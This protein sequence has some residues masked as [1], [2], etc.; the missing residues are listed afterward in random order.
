MTDNMMLDHAREILK[1]TADDAPVHIDIVEPG[2]V[3]VQGGDSAEHVYLLMR[4]RLQGEVPLHVGAQLMA[5][6]PHVVEYEPGTLI[7]ATQILT[8]S[9]HPST[10]TVTRRSTLAVLSREDFETLARTEVAFMGAV[11]RLALQQQRAS[12]TPAIAHHDPHV[13]VVLPLSAGLHPFSEQLVAHLRP[14][15]TATLINLAT[16]D[17]S[18]VTERMN[19]HDY[20]VVQG[21]S[22]SANE[23]R[24]TRLLQDSADQVLLVGRDEDLRRAD[25]PLLAL[26]E[27]FATEVKTELVIVHPRRDTQPKNTAALVKHYPVSQ[28]HHLAIDESRDYARL[29]RHLRG[30]AV[31]IVFGGGGM[32]GMAHVGVYKAML[33][34]GIVADYV[35]GT[36][37]GSIVAAQVGQEDSPEK[38]FQE[39]RDN[40]LT[41]KAVMQLTLPY[42]SF[43]TAEAINAA[44][45]KLFG[46][47]DIEDLWIPVFTIATNLTQARMEVL[48]TGSLHHAVRASSSLAGIHPPVIAENNDVLIDGGGFNNTPADVMRQ[49]VTSGTVIAVDLG[50]TKR[51]FPEFNMGYSLNG[52]SVLL[53]RLNPFRRE[54]ITFP[55]ITTTM[56][57]SNALWSMQA[58]ELQIAA[59]DLVL[60]PPVNDYGLFDLGAA[61]ELFNGGYES[62]GEPIEAWIAEGGLNGV[63]ADA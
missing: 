30:K 54:K 63:Y 19:T 56:L 35:G 31:G 41:K 17:S 34:H 12:L 29:V 27:R 42:A 38:M 32:R 11:S 44:Y 25:H 50:F 62:S 8:D 5:T 60:N 15:G 45:E 16:D 1:L 4:G 21:P 55:P 18:A 20:V 2:Q 6:T 59:A 61:D 40:I 36:S 24:L 43:S 7:G 49:K 39:T 51:E 37:S 26:F 57:R 28:H 23:E 14:F 52:F 22:A 46:G 48:D 3:L 58:T 33:E 13:I 47:Q 9:P 53:N 10:I